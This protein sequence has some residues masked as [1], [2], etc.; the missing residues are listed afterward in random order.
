[1]WADSHAAGADRGQRMLPRMRFDRSLVRVVRR[2]LRAPPWY[3][4]VT[5]GRPEAWAC[6]TR[7]WSLAAGCHPGIMCQRRN[8]RRNME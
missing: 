8:T 5:P 4:D 7:V 2:G 1:M 3:P 6:P